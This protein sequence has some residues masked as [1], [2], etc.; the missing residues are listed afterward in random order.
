[1]LALALLACGGP[2]EAPAPGLAPALTIERFLQ[3]ANAVSQMRA[4][5]SNAQR[6]AQEVE[7]MARLFGTEQGPIIDLYPRSE[8]DQRMLILADLLR[9]TD[10]RLGA[11]RAVPG[12]GGNAIEVLVEMTTAARPRQVRVPFIVVRRG[13]VWLIERIDLEPITTS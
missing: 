7:T 9:H 10:Y 12:R 3:A 13:D 5:G 6:M 1:M 11:E 8:V 4:Q 2:A